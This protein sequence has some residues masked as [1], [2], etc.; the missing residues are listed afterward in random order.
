MWQPTSD[1]LAQYHPHRQECTTI[2]RLGLW[3][4]LPAAA[5]GVVILWHRRGEHAQIGVRMVTQFSSHTQRY[6]VDKGALAAAWIAEQG[7]MWLRV[8]HGQDAGCAPQPCL[9]AAS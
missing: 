3:L 1:E 7:E 5:R 2:P 6:K 4:L 9:C 8:E